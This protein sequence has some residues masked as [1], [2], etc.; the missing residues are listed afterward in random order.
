[1]SKDTNLTPGYYVG[2]RRSIRDFSFDLPKVAKQRSYETM[3]DLWDDMV[4]GKKANS[5]KEQTKNSGNQN[6]KSTSFSGWYSAC[7]AVN[8]RDK[9]YAAPE[10]YKVAGGEDPSIA[11]EAVKKFK[12][13][14]AKVLGRCADNDLTVDESIANEINQFSCLVH[15]IKVILLRV[16]SE[17]FPGSRLNPQTGLYYGERTMRKF[18]LTVPPFEDLLQAFAAEI[19]DSETNVASDKRL[20]AVRQD[21]RTLRT[22]R[23]AWTSGFRITTVNAVADDDKALIA[24]VQRIR[25]RAGTPS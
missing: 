14:A 13:N 2:I 19:A 10:I 21:K 12:Q 9:C 7:N 22:G 18:F 5:Q 25:A 1:M 11:G 15:E 20:H 16:S 17:E 24:A 3:D 23:N 8:L 4:Y 6:E